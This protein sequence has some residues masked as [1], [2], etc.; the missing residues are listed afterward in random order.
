MQ[1]GLRIRRRTRL[2]SVQARRRARMERHHAYLALYLAVRV[3]CG[4][5]HGGLRGCRRR[6]TNPRK[7]PHLP[8]HLRRDVILKDFRAH[9]P[10]RL[11]CEPGIAAGSVLVSDSLAAEFI[12]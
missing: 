9:L 12:C 7:T 3:V 11:A 1:T 8:V 10:E 4:C 6:R 2:A 5:E